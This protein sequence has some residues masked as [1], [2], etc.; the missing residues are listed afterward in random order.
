MTSR[1]VVRP[2]GADERV[3]WEPLWRTYLDFY[4]TKLS[5]P[6]IDT[7]WA[8]LHDP[9]EQ[10]FALGAYQGDALKGIAHYLYHR[11]MWTPGDY[12]YLQDLYD[13]GRRA[14]GPEGR[15]E[16]HLLAYPGE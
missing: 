2:I 6:A 16:P 9:K 8:R 14:G 12:C 5:Q 7:A 10:M 15:R 1:A 4:K 3:A 13:R 11:S